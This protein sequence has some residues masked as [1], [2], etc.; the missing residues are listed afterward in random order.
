MFSSF[1][2]GK[3]DVASLPKRGTVNREWLDIA[4]KKQTKPS[5]NMYAEPEEEYWGDD[6]SNIPGKSHRPQQ[7]KHDEKEPPR[8][9][10]G[11]EEQDEGFPLDPAGPYA[12]I[13]SFPT[14]A[15]VNQPVKFDASKSH[16]CDN[17][18]V[19]KY[20]WDFGDGSPQVT[21]TGPY[22][23]HPYKKAQVYPVTVVVT[24]KYGKNAK[25]G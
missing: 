8:Y 3:I 10:S 20:V 25:A 5:S 14:N 18:P 22:T 15:M 11:P 9:G 24:D 13:Q 23:T 12:H 2:L 19:K 21:T 1:F 17:Q 7:R 16:D 6:A 4:A